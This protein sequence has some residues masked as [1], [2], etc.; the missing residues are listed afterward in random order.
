MAEEEVKE[1]S[2]TMEYVIIRPTGVIGTG[3][4]TSCGQVFWAVNFGFFFFL[5]DVN[6]KVCFTHISDIVKG[7]EMSIE[8]PKAKCETIILSS[9]PLSYKE[10]IKIAAKDLGRME[11]II[12]LPFNLVRATVVILKPFCSKLFPKRF[13]F[14]PKTFDQ[15][16]VNLCYSNKKAKKILGWSPQYTFEEAIHETLTV[17]LRIGELKKRSY[18]LF[19]LILL[20]LFVVIFAMVMSKFM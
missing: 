7:I 18:S 8:N 2:E 11:P 1:G 6:G 10:V 16:I 9:N 17:Q 14:E 12:T 19:F 4:F 13:L 3:D 5:P 20:T 15:M